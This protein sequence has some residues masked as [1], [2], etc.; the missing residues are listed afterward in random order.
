MHTI[1]NLTHLDA[2]RTLHVMITW[3]VNPE[4]AVN[5]YINLASIGPAIER[6]IIY[7]KLKNFYNS[8]F[9]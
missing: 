1:P 2:D 4:W 7:Y 6:E 8:Y 3:E 5:A 9:K